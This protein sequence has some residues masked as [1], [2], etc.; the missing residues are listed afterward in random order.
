MMA[1]RSYTDFDETAMPP[2]GTIRDVAARNKCTL[3]QAR[4]LMGLRPEKREQMPLRALPAGQYFL[5]N[6]LVWRKEPDGIAR[7][8]GTRFGKDT[9]HGFWAEI[10][11]HHWV[12]PLTEMDLAE[13]WEEDG[14]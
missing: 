9:M 3:A 2:I 6:E 8:Q 7:L 10:S 12:E 14:R 1:A 13:M 11:D 4:Q 5:F